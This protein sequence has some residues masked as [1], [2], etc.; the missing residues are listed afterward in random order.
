MRTQIE[1]AKP[2]HHSL[3]RMLSWILTITTLVS[4]L[5]LPVTAET[6]QHGT[7]P[8]SYGKL[9]ETAVTGTAN[10]KAAFQ[11]LELVNKE[12]KKVGKAAL[13]MD[14]AM[15]ESA[16]QRAAECSLY[17]S[18]T[19]PNGKDPYSLIPHTCSAGE[20]IAAGFGTPA[21]VMEGWMNS[22]GHRSNILDEYNYGFKSIGIGVF[23]VGDTYYWCQLFNGDNKKANPTSKKAVTETRTIEIR[24]QM[25][26]LTINNTAL[27]LKDGQS[28]QLTVY[29]RNIIFYGE[30]TKLAATGLTFA[31]TDTNVATVNGKG[32]VTAVGGGNATITVKSKN[33]ITLFSVPVT[34]HSTVIKAN[35][36]ATTKGTKLT[37]SAVS[38]AEYYRVYKSTYSGG[39]WG[40]VKLYKTTKS[41]FCVDTTH[42]AG[43]KTKYTIYAYANGKKIGTHATVTATHLCKSTVKAVSTAKGE[44]ISWNKT[45]G[46]SY[47]TVSRRVYSNGK[48]SAYTT[49]KTTKSLSYTDTKIKAG[50]KAQYAVVAHSGSNQSLKAT[51]TATYLKQP[52]VKLAKATKGVKISWGKIS[53]A[54]TYQVY[55][56]VYKNGKWSSYSYYKTTKSTSYTDT[57]VK[58]GQK[59]RYT[60]Y[61]VCGSCHK[62][63]SA[64]K[65]GVNITR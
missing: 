64:T 13:V 46:A 43:Q 4:L 40:T 41:L 29:N 7:T 39:K 19:R 20:N 33:G 18:H 55:K 52:N 9:Y 48:W 44:K 50:Q 49:I 34:V 58:K 24:Q 28:S 65:T 30:L 1:D 60:I 16:M 32:K 6:H 31:S 45:T 38:D 47:Y 26:D 11:V 53:G 22:P 25:M 23:K 5:A 57:T 37:W 2:Q 59:V 56:S 8:E 42:Q 36:I 12:R 54:G 27:E 15:L 3:R 14:K 61:A 51:C 17:Y 63:K 62:G 10:Y 35:T 21:N